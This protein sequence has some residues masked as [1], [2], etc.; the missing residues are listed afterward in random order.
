MENGFQKG[1]YDYIMGT[2]LNES[3]NE[4][5]SEILVISFVNGYYFFDYNNE[6]FKYHF[7]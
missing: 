7:Y 6:E 4:I 1:G 5:Y 2:N 3:E